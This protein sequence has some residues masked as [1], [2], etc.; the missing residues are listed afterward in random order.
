MHSIFVVSAGICLEQVQIHSYTH[1]A[2]NDIHIALFGPTSIMPFYM[3]WYWKRAHKCH[4]KVTWPCSTSHCTIS[5][6]IPHRIIP[7]ASIGSKIQFTCLF[8]PMFKHHTWPIDPDICEFWCRIHRSK[9]CGQPK[10][11]SCITHFSRCFRQSHVTLM[12]I[13]WVKVSE[14]LDLVMGRVWWSITHVWV[15]RVVKVTPYN[16]AHLKWM[17]YWHNFSCAAH[18]VWEHAT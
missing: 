12:V 9:G 8:I 15:S 14:T 1:C 13:E 6:A 2:C 18:H 10:V 16:K 3:G 11:W 5:L 7:F 4:P 17:L